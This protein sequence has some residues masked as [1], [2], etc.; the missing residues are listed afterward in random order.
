MIFRTQWKQYFPN[1]LIFDF[2]IDSIARGSFKF[3]NLLDSEKA[4][5]L[6]EAMRLTKEKVTIH[7]LINFDKKNEQPVKVS[8]VVPVCNV[9]QY[10]RDCLDSCV[11][12][13]LQDIEIICVNDGSKD[14][15]LEILKEY[16]AKDSRV[17]VINKDNAGYG[18][19]MNIG[20]DMAVGEYIGI[21]ESDDYVESNMYEVLYDLAVQNDIDIVKGDFYRFIEIDG[22]KDCNHIK[23]A[24]SSYYDKVINPQENYEVFQFNMQTWS[25]IYKKSFLTDNN[26]R[27]NETPGASFQDNGFCFKSFCWATRV[28][29]TNIPFYYYRFDNPNSSIHN[30]GKTDLIKLEFDLIKDYID[31]EGVNET[32]RKLYYWKKFKSYLYT[33]E[34]IAYE[35]KHDFFIE[36][37]KEFK[38]LLNKNMLDEECF[39]KADWEKLLWITE[40]P[41]E[42]Y[43]IRVKRQKV[44]VII[45]VYNVEDYV[46]ECL[47]SVVNQTL[48]EIEIICINDGSTDGSLKK[49]L[50]FAQRDK[51]VQIYNQANIGVGAT[52]NKGIDMAHGE[53]LIFM[54]PDD[55]YPSDDVL[56]TL[57]DNA[58]ENNVLAS[59]GSFSD[60]VGSRVNTIF[61]G[62]LSDYIFETDGIVEYKNYQFDYGFHRFIYNTE[63]L[64]ENKIYFPKLKRFQDP[65][66]FIKA[67]NTAGCFYATSKTVY[68]YRRASHPMVWNSEKLIDALKGVEYD[69]KM[70]AELGYSKLHSL[71]LQRVFITFK[72]P[73]HDVISFENIELLN[74]ISSINASV[75]ESLIDEN[76]VEFYRKD[77]IWTVIIRELL[78]D[79][80]ELRKSTPTARIIRLENEVKNLKKVVNQR[81][82]YKMRLALTRAS[83]AFRIGRAITWLPR[84]IKRIFKKSK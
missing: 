19:T 45:P 27:H 2:K 14:S 23:S 78:K 16:A 32:Y 8:I 10:L 6:N 20:M 83:F 46:E 56:E 68:R 64:R 28:Y 74:V 18:H 33:V 12:Q 34:R 7:E 79:K 55:F 37:S 81:D 75:D 76:I 22:N 66:F 61:K 11:N 62:T 49:L 29:Y 48:K 51:R 54:D 70:S 53:F 24:W 1:I 50:P 9:E 17:K 36:L 69:L 59:G 4:K 72:N 84:L 57:Y 30:R 43:N 21:V 38:E 13:T 41:E 47:E 25:G 42:Y 77:F 44:T 15:S 82:D 67:L 60:L 80:L 31:A 3:M 26:I 63:M 71:S 65:P 39:G 35:L 58:V 40:N 52:R 5:V 73:L